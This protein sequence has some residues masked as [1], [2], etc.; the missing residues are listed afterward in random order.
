MMELTALAICWKILENDGMMERYGKVQYINNV[1]K[2]LK[3][4]GMVELKPMSYPAFFC[5]KILENDGIMGQ[6]SIK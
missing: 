5:R 2:Y 6:V 1:G 3:N 4:D